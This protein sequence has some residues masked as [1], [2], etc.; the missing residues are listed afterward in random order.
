MKS[1]KKLLSGESSPVLDCGDLQLQAALSME[2][3]SRTPLPPSPTS[4]L[5][6][7]PNFKSQLSISELEQ[8]LKKPVKPAKPPRKGLIPKKPFSSP[9]PSN[10]YVYETVGKY[11]AVEYRSDAWR[12]LGIDEPNHSEQINEENEQEDYMSW[13]QFR[14]EVE[15]IKP[16]VQPLAPKVIAQGSTTSLDDSYYD[17]LNFF[18]ST[19][20]LSAKSGYKQVL[21]IPVAATPYQPSFN[22]YDEVQCP[23]MEPVRSADDSHL[24]YALVRKD[25][26]KDSLR[27]VVT[28]DKKKKEKD[29][30]SHQFHNEEPYAVISKPKR[31]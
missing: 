5:I 2:A 27:E 29:K 16:P 28:D 6:Q 15:N 21:P 19:S 20:K 11:D 7:D 8:A 13:G 17:R 22:E 31:V 24:G 3:R 23:D 9:A 10:D 30:V 1:M 25:P 4:Q 14:K 18:G 26:G 12:T